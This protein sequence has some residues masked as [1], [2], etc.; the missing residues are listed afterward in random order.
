VDV[1]SAPAKVNGEGTYWITVLDAGVVNTPRKSRSGGLDT[2][3]VWG[4][5]GDAYAVWNGTV[6]WAGLAGCDVANGK[7]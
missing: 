6:A 1:E 4:Q 5:C 2:L 7:C 3:G